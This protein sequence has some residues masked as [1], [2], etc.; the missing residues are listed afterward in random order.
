M[1][2]KPKFNINDHIAT[3]AYNVLEAFSDMIE[4]CPNG[5]RE[6]RGH[7]TMGYLKLDKELVIVRRKDLIAL[8]KSTL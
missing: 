6:R 5:I 3:E 4:P 7:F 2:R 1:P 8:I